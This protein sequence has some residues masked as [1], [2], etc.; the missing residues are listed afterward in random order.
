MPVKDGKGRGL[1]RYFKSGLSKAFRG[2]RRENSSARL[3]QPD[4]QA[5]GSGVRV[6]APPVLQR[7]WLT[8]EHIR[9]DYTLLER[10]LQREHPDLAARMRLLRPAQAQ[11][12]RLNHDAAELLLAVQGIVYDEDENDTADFLFVPVNN[13]RGVK[14]DDGYHW[15]LLLLDRRNREDV[16]AYHYDSSGKSNIA[17]AEQLAENLG[18]NL[19]SAPMAQQ[20]NNYDCGV[21][22]VDGTRALARRLAEGERPESLHLDNLVADRRALQDRLSGRA[23]SR[24]PTR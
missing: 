9:A 12:L 23:H 18:A 1:W 14:A 11:M 3:D 2:S 16:V 19:Q 6:R 4:G 13:G 24:R 20:R 7:S 10:E 5:S 15:S 8:D 22:V 17:S 21:F